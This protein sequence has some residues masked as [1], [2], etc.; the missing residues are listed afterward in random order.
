M[1]PFSLRDEA[2]EWAYSLEPGEIITW[3]QMMEK[4]MKKQFPSIEDS[5]RRRDIAH[6]QQKDRETLSDKWV[7]FKRLV[8]NCPHNG[9]FECIQMEIFYDGLNEASQTA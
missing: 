6:F 1:F 4:F 8:R 3:E 7:R 9:F 2:R 5:K